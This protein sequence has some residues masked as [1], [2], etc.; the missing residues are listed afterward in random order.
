MVDLSSD[1]VFLFSFEYDLSKDRKFSH[2]GDFTNI[3]TGAHGLKSQHFG[4]LLGCSAATHY[5]IFSCLRDSMFETKIA[6]YI[7]TWNISV[8]YFF[9]L[10]RS[11]TLVTQAGVQWRDLGSP[12]PPPPVF[13]Q[14]CCLSLLS[15]WDYRHAPP[16]PANFLYF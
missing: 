7:P 15:S 16:W 9:F 4:T 14:F 8:I 2:I 5:N 13:R 11:F 12:Q 1:S 6:I 3:G 10:R